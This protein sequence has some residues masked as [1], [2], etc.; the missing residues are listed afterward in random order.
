ILD[1]LVILDVIIACFCMR[2]LVHCMSDYKT[3]NGKFS[4]S[5]FI[6]RHTINNLIEDAVERMA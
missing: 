5:H 3:D 1:F 6:G 4:M 2:Q